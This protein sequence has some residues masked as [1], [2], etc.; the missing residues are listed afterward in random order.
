MDRQHI[1]SNIGRSIAAQCLAL[2]V[3]FWFPSPIFEVC[4]L[5]E[6]SYLCGQLPEIFAGFM[7][8]LASFYLGPKSKF[9]YM[10]VFILFAYIGSAKNIRF[11]GQIFEVLADVPFQTFYYGG[12]LALLI[13]VVLKSIFAGCVKSVPNK[14]I[15][16]DSL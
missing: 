5:D 9:H 6:N 11:G 1:Y 13:I 10:S 12:A 4:L 8:V 2:F 16:R 7:F 15:N 3:I 14:G